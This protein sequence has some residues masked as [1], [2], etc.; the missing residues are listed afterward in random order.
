[1]LKKAFFITGT[2]TDSGKTFFAASLAAALFDAG[3]SVGV[4]KPIESGCRKV[5]G[6][7]VPED[8]SL[9]KKAS[10]TDQPLSDI[11][12][13]RLAEPL[14]P[15]EAARMQGVTVEP[16]R[17]VRAF[18]QIADTHDITLVEGAGGL[19]APLFDRW[20]VLEL[21]RQLNVPVIHVVGS[22]LGAINHT[23]LS[24]RV[25]LEES[26]ELVGHVINNLY[27]S[28][29]RAALTNPDLVKRLARRPVLAVLPR[30]ESPWLAPG[31]FNKRFDLNVLALGT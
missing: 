6:E 2:D 13:Y 9:L 23:L 8:A 31:G 4:F 22:K 17:V 16:E 30:S 5:D 1:M 20:T 24:E 27:G 26:V 28:D 12:L 19:M 11:C 10:G 14:A 21:A 7:L 3:Y 18:E 25:I 29:D 15:S